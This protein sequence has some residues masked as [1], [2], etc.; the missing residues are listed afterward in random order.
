[1][2]LAL[3]EKAIRLRGL[4]PRGAFHVGAV[5]EVPVTARGP[6]QTLV[7]AGSIGPS[8]WPAFSASPEFKLEVDGL[9]RW[10]RRVTSELALDLGAEALFPFGGPPHH[11]FQRWARRAEPVHPSPLGILIHPRHGLWHAYRAALVFA[12]RIEL[13]SKVD[14]PSP[15]PTCVGKPCLTSCPVAAFG[16]G[17]YDVATCVAQARGRSGIE[18]RERGCMARRACP[19]GHAMAY[20]PEQQHFHMAAFLKGQ[21]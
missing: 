10:T 17:F 13:P 12:E 16:D 5:D 9:D 8:L 15:C 14:E 3:I 21:R 19:V 18:C 20:D 1:M 2:T 11:P 4:E 6:A 7:L